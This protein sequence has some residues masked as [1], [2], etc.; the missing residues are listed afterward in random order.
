M[1][2]S[3]KKNDISLPNVPQHITFLE[4][5]IWSSFHFHQ[6]PPTVCHVAVIPGKAEKG[7]LTRGPSMYL[8]Q[9]GHYVVMKNYPIILESPVGHAFLSYDLANGGKGQS[10]VD[11]NL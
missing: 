4:L 9:N 5:T 2:A 8:A 3:N 11:P 7:P 10:E 6:L 1:I